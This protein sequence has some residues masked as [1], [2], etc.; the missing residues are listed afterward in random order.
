MSS[1]G[2]WELAVGVPADLS[3]G[4][5]NLVWELGALGVVEEEQ[6]G[7]GARL[8]AFFPGTIFPSALEAQ[9]RAYLDGLRELGFE[10]P[11]DVSVVALADENWADAWRAHFTPRLVGRRLLILPPWETPSANGRIVIT[12]DPGRAFGTGHHGSTIGCL[13][14]LESVIERDSPSGMIDLG[15][16]SGIL[17]IAAPRLGVRAVLAG[18]DDPHPGAPPGAHRAP[19]PLPRPIPGRVA[20]PAPIR[21]APRP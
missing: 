1:P 8:R 11:T 20:H 10:P 12:I 2:F 3:E 19:K 9:V 17:A 18:G 4:L 15:T 5:T 7:Q 13:E 21:A 16:G 14:A 6:P